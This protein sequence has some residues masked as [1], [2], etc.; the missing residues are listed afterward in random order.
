MAP[1]NTRVVRRTQALFVAEGEAAFG[2]FCYEEGLWS[3]GK[4]PWISL[5]AT[6][7]ERGSRLF[8]KSRTLRRMLRPLLPKP[9]EG[10]SEKS[11]VNGFMKLTLLGTG[12]DGRTLRATFRG[13]GDPG[14]RITTELFCEAAFCLGLP[15]E[16]RKLPAVSGLL[17]PAYALRDTLMERVKRNPA[18]SLD[19]D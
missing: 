11:Q 6:L 7:G 8:E 18:F 14:N 1:I 2:T 19:W 13:K 5:A 16:R 10:P 3:Q 17:T 15:E 12:T 4:L 9:G